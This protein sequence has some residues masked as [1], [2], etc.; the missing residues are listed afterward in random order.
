VEW[1]DI[2][3][4]MLQGDDI[5]YTQ[6]GTKAHHKEDVL[7]KVLD[8]AKRHTDPELLSIVA[9]VT[10][11][12]VPNLLAN[13]LVGMQAISGVI[14]QVTKLK[15]SYSDATPS[16]EIIEGVDYAQFNSSKLKIVLVKEVV[17]VKKHAFH[18]NTWVHG[19]EMNEG[20]AEIMSNI[21]L[22][23]IFDLDTELLI[24]LRNMAGTP[25]VTYSSDQHNGNPTYVGDGFASLAIMINR[26]CNLI[27]ARTRRG[28][29]NRL[30]VSP[31]AL[32]ILRSATTSSFCQPYEP[33]NTLSKFKYVGTLNSCC[34]IFL[35]P[36]A[37]PNVPVLVMYKGAVTDG[38][39]FAPYL[40][41]VIEDAVDGVSALSSVNAYYDYG[42]EDFF[43]SVGITVDTLS[44]V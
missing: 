9:A 43:G 16:N 21:V 19:L 10:R 35:D 12:I 15:V 1:T 11:R 13:E 32:T 25:A 20:A 42:Q 7:R 29:G 2:R 14:G 8:N 22:N 18:S 26:Q 40:P 6:S 3:E 5:K 37:E 44:F 31:A 27:A 24:S 36:F 4:S 23:C 39:I 33:V 38:P 17:E 28:A 34:E 41:F 30:V